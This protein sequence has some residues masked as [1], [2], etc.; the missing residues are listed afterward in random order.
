MESSYSRE[1]RT[2]IPHE[3]QTR[4]LLKQTEQTYAFEEEFCGSSLV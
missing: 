4:L 1:K 3:P 2:D